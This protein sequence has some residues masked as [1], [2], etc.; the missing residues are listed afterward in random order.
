VLINVKVRGGSVEPFARR[1]RAHLVQN[2]VFV[3]DADRG[4]GL[5]VRALQEQGIGFA[6][7]KSNIIVCIDSSGVV[8]VEEGTADVLIA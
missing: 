3:L 5:N 2:I 8:D 7:G 6:K 1:V 4:G